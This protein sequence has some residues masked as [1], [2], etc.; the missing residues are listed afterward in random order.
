MSEHIPF[1][2]AAFDALA[3]SEARH[4]WFRARNQLLVWILRS[5]VGE[6]RNF[7]EIGCGTG[8]VLDGIR[9]EF[10]DVELFGTEFF[11]E[12]LMHAR[13]RIPSAKFEQL[14]ARLMSDVER[15][16]MI[17]AFDV[18]E[19][20]DEDEVVLTNISR[21]L[22]KGG[23]LLVTVPQHRWLW[24]AADERAC[25]VR[26]YTRGELID[27]VRGAG[28]EVKYVT[29]FVSLLM[30]LMWLSR[31]RSGQKDAETNSEFDI[32][33]ATNRL[34]AFVMKIELKLIKFGVPLPFGGSLL[35]LA[36][37]P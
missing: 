34:L 11:E 9:H 17:G 32:S 25:H 19:H 21:A 3:S 12:G 28:L 5:R 16:D 10:P 6:F 14:D 18:I 29:S 15:Y 35:V 24:S 30:P 36:R 13:Q 37:K 8:F 23:H 20:I 33:D 22:R 4:W 1:P 27:K 26:R 2:K 31:Q 7:L